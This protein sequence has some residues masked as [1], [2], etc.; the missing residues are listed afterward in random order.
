[1]GPTGHPIGAGPTTDVAGRRAVGSPDDDR[2]PG[3]TALAAQA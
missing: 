3:P 2:S 1:M